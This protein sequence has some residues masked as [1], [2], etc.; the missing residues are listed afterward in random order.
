MANSGLAALLRNVK[1][2]P[3]R[4]PRIL[5]AYARRREYCEP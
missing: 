1:M 5:E 3:A 4:N 2:N